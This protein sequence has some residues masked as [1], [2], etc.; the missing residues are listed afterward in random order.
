LELKV[1]EAKL[2]YYKRKIAMLSNTHNVES[3]LDL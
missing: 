2:E 3:W 1:Q